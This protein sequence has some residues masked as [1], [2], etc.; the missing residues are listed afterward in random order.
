MTFGWNSLE[1][2][3]A[4]HKWMEIAGFV[5]LGLLLTSEVIA[6]VYGN[7]KDV[8]SEHETRKQLESVKAAQQQ[9]RLSVEQKHILISALS[10]FRGQKVSVARIMGDVEAEPLADDFVEVLVK[11]GWD[12]GGKPGTDQSAYDK[13]PV[14]IEVTL[15]QAEVE[16]GRLPPAAKA[17]I[18]SLAK[19]SIINGDNAFVNPGIPADSIEIRV[20]KKP[21][22][23][24]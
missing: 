20:G 2:V 3:S 11:A 16:A 10:P 6:F 7:R 21:P 18:V 4:I 17:L 12:F 24:R 1:S 13:D 14:G 9:R 23:S 22:P 8:L 19:L 5:F 15:N